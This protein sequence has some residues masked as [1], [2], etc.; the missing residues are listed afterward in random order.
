VLGIGWPYYFIISG[1]VCL[2]G[3]RIMLIDDSTY[4]EQQRIPLPLVVA[5][6]IV[7]ALAWP[8]VPFIWG[9]RRLYKFWKREKG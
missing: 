9:G 1:V 5:V 2:M 7:T 4:I 3:L 6:T 8:A